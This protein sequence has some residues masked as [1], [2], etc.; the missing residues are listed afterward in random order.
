LAAGLKRSRDLL[1]DVW[2]AAF[3]TRELEDN[4]GDAVEALGILAYVV[5]E[6]YSELETGVQTMFPVTT[7]PCA[8]LK[9]QLG[10]LEGTLRAES[11]VPRWIATGAAPRSPSDL[12]Y[13]SDARTG[14]G[15]RGF[16]AREGAVPVSGEKGQAEAHVA[17]LTTNAAA[18]RR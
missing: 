15:G 5:N 14:G 13:G 7:G 17:L 8:F 6:S 2:R 1:D 9:N 10:L 16:R 18:R 3:G 11:G 12:S 4:D